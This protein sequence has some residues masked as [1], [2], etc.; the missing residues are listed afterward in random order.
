M[1]PS[2]KRHLEGNTSNLGEGSP[3]KKRRFD[4]KDGSDGPTVI[5]TRHLDSR[6]LITEG[7]SDSDL[8]GSLS[9]DRDG[10]A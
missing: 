2:R 6:V 4:R 8:V 10:R 7:P 5:E 9:S 3:Q 1:A